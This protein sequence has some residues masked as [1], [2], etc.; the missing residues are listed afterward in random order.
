MNPYPIVHTYPESI[1]GVS[2][3]PELKDALLSS[4]YIEGADWQIS[5]PSAYGPVE[6]IGRYRAP[7]RREEYVYRLQPCRTPTGE[8]WWHAYG[9]Y[10]PFGRT[11]MDADCVFLDGGGFFAKRSAAL[12]AIH[13]WLA[14]LH[15]AD[16][17][18]EAAQTL[19]H[20]D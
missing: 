1:G 13:L 14:H 4:G 11:V 15:Q 17:E 2:A 16:A 6:D 12:R 3:C 8:I 18:N 10:C 9:E 5:D 20:G 19:S 7:G